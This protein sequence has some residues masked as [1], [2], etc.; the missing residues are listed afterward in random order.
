MLI[1]R[2]E[3]A[4]TLTP[5]MTQSQVGALIAIAAI[6]PQG[7]A[8]TGRVGHPA[9][10]YDR[11]AI[12]Q[13]HAAEA[14]RTSKQF[15]DNDWLASALLGRGLII[16]DPEAGTLHWP[17]G[18]RAETMTDAI[19]GAV[20]VKG[21]QRVM[22]H[23]TIWIAAEGEIPHGIQ[24]NHLNRLRWDNRRANLELVTWMENIRH[25]NGKLYLTHPEAIGQLATLEPEPDIAPQ[26]WDAMRRAGATWRKHR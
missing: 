26:P 2:Q 23:R 15:T 22:A 9:Y 17:D 18:S 20:T 24:I 6:D 16:A 5:A 21:S 1:T 4:A 12:V 7:T 25:A 8:R 13:A 14:A 10:L 3:A 11:D 19:Y